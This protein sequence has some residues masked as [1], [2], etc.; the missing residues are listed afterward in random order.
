MSNYVYVELTWFLGLVT[1]F[2]RNQP[3]LFQTAGSA[4]YQATTLDHDPSESMTSENGLICGV[5]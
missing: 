3:G 4:E 1:G 5:F 2:P